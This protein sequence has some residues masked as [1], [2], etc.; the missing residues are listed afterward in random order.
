MAKPRRKLLEA[1]NVI[2]PGRSDEEAHVV[3]DSTNNE[4]APLPE[5][6]D[7]TAKAEYHSKEAPPSKAAEAGIEERRSD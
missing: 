4:S 7:T 5:D 1:E 2:E 6:T 3:Q